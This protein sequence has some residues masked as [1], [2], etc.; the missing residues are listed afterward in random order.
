MVHGNVS[1]YSSPTSLKQILSSSGQDLSNPSQNH[2][3]FNS[4]C[5]L[6]V[7][8]PCACYWQFY[9]SEYS[10]VPSMLKS[11]FVSALNLDLHLNASVRLRTALSSRGT[12][13]AAGQFLLR[14][15]HSIS[16]LAP[17]PL[18]VYWLRIWVYY[19][20]WLTPLFVHWAPYLSVLLTLMNIV[21]GGARQPW[22]VSS[23]KTWGQDPSPQILMTSALSLYMYINLNFALAQNISQV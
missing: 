9:P 13:N 3:S 6:T 21:K 11:E 7:Y 1:W 15:S 23:A 10:L 17:A 22:P 5:C 16:S 19:E 18:F 4:R 12:D 20:P 2:F 14:S 8:T